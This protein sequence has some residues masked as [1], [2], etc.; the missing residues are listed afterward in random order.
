M[1]DATPGPRARRAAAAVLGALTLLLAGCGAPGAGS[2]APHP[3]TS[4]ADAAGTTV[5]RPEHVVVVIEENH[6]YGQIIGDTADAPYLNTLAHEGASFTHSFAITHPSEPNYLAL[7]SGSTHGVT[8]DSCPH[9]YPGPDLGSE[10]AAAGLG[11]AGYSEGLPATGFTGCTSGLYARKHNPW[12][13]FTDV[14]ASANQPFT[15]FPSDYARLP[16]VSFVVPDLNDDMHNGTV[17]QGDTWLRQNL[18]GYAAWARTHDSL[19]VVTWD[20]DDNSAANQIPTIVVGQD[21]RPGRY[22]ETLDHY[23]L[24]RTLE[25][26]YHLAHAGDAAAVTPVTDAFR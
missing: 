6:S 5:P 2:T 23:R 21:V 1:T 25:D 9:S 4:G 17:Q 22:A 16:T 13:D 3:G 18:G 11:F 7:F 15:A 10:L 8:D 14:P 19:L 26:A 12:V 24:L 20:E